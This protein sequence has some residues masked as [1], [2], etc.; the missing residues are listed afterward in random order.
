MSKILEKHVSLHFYKYLQHRKLLIDSQFG[1]RRNQSCQTALITLSEKIYQAL[2]AGD[3]FGLVQLDLSK[4][5]DLVNHS[6]LLQKLKLYNCS[7]TAVSW[8]QSSQIDLKSFLS[9]VSAPHIITCGVPQG[10][11]LGPL[12]FL[13]NMND[14]P[15]YFKSCSEV[16]YSDDAT[17]TKA[18]SNLEIIQHDLSSD[19]HCA[20]EWCLDNAMILSLPKCVSL[21][22]ATSQKVNKYQDVKLNVNINNVDLPCVSSTKLFGFHFDSNLS[23]KEHVA[24]IRKKISKNLY[25]LKRSK[26]FLPLD[27]RKL[28]YDS[29]I[30]PYFDHCSIIWG[31]CPKYVMSDLEKIQKRA[32]MVILD[33]DINTISHILFSELH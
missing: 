25:L 10:S 8:F 33:K 9:T 21:L 17:L 3:Y 12:L 15:L 11:I 24:H 27:A 30:L 18:A 13:V 26:G 29:Y 32:A 14:L 31:T 28:F 1:Y 7:P 4:A 19:V 5:F 6:L 22:I 20:F 23:W 2:K 16:L